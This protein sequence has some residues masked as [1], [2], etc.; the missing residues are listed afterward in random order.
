MSVL[1]ETRN[2]APIQGTRPLG[3]RSRDRF[4]LPPASHAAT[5]KRFAKI[6]GAIVLLAAIMIALVAVDVAIWLPHFQR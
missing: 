2:T 4:L 1:T 3:Q 6:A 5:I